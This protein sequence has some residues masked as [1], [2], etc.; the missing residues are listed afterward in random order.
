MPD[1]I[2]F[3]AGGGGEAY[4]LHTSKKPDFFVDNNSELWG[5]TLLGREIRPPSFLSDG[6]LSIIVITSGYVSSIKRQLIELGIPSQKIKI[7]PKA[8]LGKHFFSS[9]KNREKAAAFLGNFTR[10]LSHNFQLVCL[11]GTALGFCR[12]KDFIFWDFDIDLTAPLNGKKDILDYLLTANCELNDTAEGK[13]VAKLP[14]NEGENIP[15]GIDFF[16][17]NLDHIE[18]VYEDF[19]WVWPISMFTE[20]ETLSIHGNDLFVPSPHDYYLSKVYGKDWSTPN[21]EFG[22]NDYGE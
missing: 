20:C 3:G 21:P 5:K 22:Y 15:M 18:D 17:P 14:L 4:S 8:Y 1:V 19:K 11:G 7:P 10:E 16:D 12:D 6:N 2:Y 9:K 13:I